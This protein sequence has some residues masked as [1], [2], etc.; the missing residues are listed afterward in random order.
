MLQAFESLVDK[1]SIDLRYEKG[2][3]YGGL[4]RMPDKNIMIINSNLPTEQKIKLIASEL[5][6]IEL[7]HVY[8]RPILREVMSEAREKEPTKL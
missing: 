2:E 7:N 6:L 4:C 3:F 8:I 1:L 5:S